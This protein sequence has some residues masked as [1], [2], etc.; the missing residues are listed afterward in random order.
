MKFICGI[1]Y[2]LMQFFSKLNFVYSTQSDKDIGAEKYKK[3]K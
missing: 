3:P 1:F 2:F